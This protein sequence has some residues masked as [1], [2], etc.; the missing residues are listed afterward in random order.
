MNYKQYKYSFYLIY[1]M[2]TDIV[3]PKLSLFDKIE[4]LIEQNQE[5]L[6]KMKYSYDNM[7][8][9]QK[10][11]QKMLVKLKSKSTKNN[12]KPKAN[13]KPCGFAR[14][15]PVSDEMCDFL[16]KE[17]G[18]LVSRTAVTQALIQYIKDHNLQNP[19]KKRQILPDETLYKLFGETA[20]NEELTYFTMQKYVNHHFK[21]VEPTPA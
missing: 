10:Q 9:R 8:N 13:R 17:K 3:A 1:I 11:L 6:L 2:S 16:K 12:N 5:E 18:E 7:K 21:K 14:P 20:R 4:L 15:T 19:E